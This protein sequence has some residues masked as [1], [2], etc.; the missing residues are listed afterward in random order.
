[1]IESMR[2]DSGK[3]S[4]ILKKAKST[5][6]VPELPGQ[7]INNPNSIPIWYQEPRNGSL[8]IDHGKTG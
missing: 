1:M 7:C 2:G 3:T 4:L 5:S 8:R 6:C